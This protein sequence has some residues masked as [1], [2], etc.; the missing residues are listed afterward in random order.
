MQ[1]LSLLK[2][3]K[4]VINNHNLVINFDDK[5]VKFVADNAYDSAF[6]ARPIKRY[7]QK[8]I[9][10]KLAMEIIKGNLVEGD[11]ALLTVSNNNVIELQ[12]NN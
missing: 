6:G 9:E 10:N 12:T 2:L 11:V 4:R 5:I 8:N 7:I 1:L 3:K